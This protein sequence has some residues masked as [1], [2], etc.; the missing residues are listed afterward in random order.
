MTR[1]AH[2]A[3][4]SNGRVAFSVQKKHVVH[5]AGFEWSCLTD[6]DVKRWS[7]QGPSYTVKGEEI[8]HGLA[9]TNLVLSSGLYNN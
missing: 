8:E 6:E 5:N 7:D 1:R 2:E 9:Y 4:S 3:I